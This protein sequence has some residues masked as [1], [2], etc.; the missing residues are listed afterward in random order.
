MNK[1]KRV[2]LLPQEKESL[3]NYINDL[4][5]ENGLDLLEENPTDEN[6]MDY[7][8]K[9]SEDEEIQEDFLTSQDNNFIEYLETIIYQSLVWGI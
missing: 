3:K 9:I 6:T 8:E 5:E 1:Y 4:I 7:I 2:T